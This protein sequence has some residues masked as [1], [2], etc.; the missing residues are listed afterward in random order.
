MQFKPLTILALAG[1]LSGMAMGQTATPPAPLHH[2][3]KPGTTT[4]LP[5]SAASVTASDAV[6]TLT[7]AC[8]DNTK[9]CVSSVSREQFEKIAN[10]LRP[11]MTSE[12]RRQ[13][14]TQYGKLLVFADAARALGLENDPKYQQILQFAQDQILVEALN[15][16]YSDEYSHPSDQQIQQ[17]YDQNH[18]KYIEANLQRIIIPLQPAAA[19]ITKPT[20]AEQKAYI[21]KV[22]QEWIGGGDPL[23]LEAE[24]LKR[25]GLTSSAP[26]VNLTKQRPGMLAVEHESVF[27][28]KPNEVSQPFVDAGAAYLYKM[29]T[30]SQMPLSEVKP[31]ITKTLHDQ[32]LKDKVQEVSE[33]AKPVLNEAYFGADKPATANPGAPAGAPAD[34]PPPSQK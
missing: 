34:T 25:M 13:F 15:Q 2:A 26:D 33:S 31:Q 4:A 21:E 29:I 14:A 11:D 17:Y 20:E 6:I 7:G 9:G 5:A 1:A 18:G 32:M 23:K 12:M 10:A 3:P 27:Q 30:S 28:L 8:K 22:R 19:E 16:H 24:G